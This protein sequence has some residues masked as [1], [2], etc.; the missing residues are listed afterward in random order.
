MWPVKASYV[1]AVAKTASNKSMYIL[2]VEIK[3]K[4]ILTAFDVTYLGMILS[5]FPLFPSPNNLLGLG[6]KGN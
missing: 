3:L 2:Q 4:L 1:F 6:E 5:L